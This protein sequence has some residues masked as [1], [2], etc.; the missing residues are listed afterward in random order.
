MV[1]QRYLS[2]LVSKMTKTYR[3]ILIEKYPDRREEIEAIDYPGLDLIK[4]DDWYFLLLSS[5]Q[6]YQ[7][8]IDEWERMYRDDMGYGGS[9]RMNPKGR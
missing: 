5:C 9:W 7:D 1:I 3:Q 6:Y 8:K 2:G 4:A